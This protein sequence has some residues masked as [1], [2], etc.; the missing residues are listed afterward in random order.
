M[1]IPFLELLI[2]P[3]QK[4]NHRG[5]HQ[6]TTSLSPHLTL[7]PVILKL[8]AATYLSLSLTRPILPTLRLLWTI[9]RIFHMPYCL[10]S[11][12]GWRATPLY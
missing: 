4:G 11:I 8:R 10:V 12:I 3:H 5:Q 6:W 2:K 9:V 7:Y 1:G